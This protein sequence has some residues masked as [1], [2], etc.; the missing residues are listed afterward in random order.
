MS[1]KL[2]NIIEDKDNDLEIVF[3]STKT[4]EFKGAHSIGCKN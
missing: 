3:D 4:E 2:K 1:Q